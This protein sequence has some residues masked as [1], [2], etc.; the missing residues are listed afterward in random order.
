MRPKF[1]ADADLDGRVVRGLKRALPEID[2]RTAVEAELAGALDRDV[3]R[4]AA[5]G[6]RVLVS[7]DRRT[8]P[9]HFQR[10]VAG[11]K[12]PGVIL[13]REGT[14]IAAA[15]EDLVLIWSASEA[16]EWTDRLLWIPL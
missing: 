14:S 4:I 1:Q 5:E 3:L 9:G 10:F 2:I 7:Q 15:I 6:G 12:S 8:M 13:I 11:A 16:D